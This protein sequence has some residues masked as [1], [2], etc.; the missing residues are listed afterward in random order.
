V[1]DLETGAPICEPITDLRDPVRAVDMVT[2]AGREVLVYARSNNVRARYFWSFEDERQ[3]K[4]ARAE[5]QELRQGDQVP[6]SAESMTDTPPQPPRIGDKLSRHGGRV[7]AVG[8]ANG[9]PIVI[10][11][12]DHG[13]IDLFTVET[14]LPI[15]G[16]LTGHSS[17]IT[18]LAF[19]ELHGG[20]VIASGST[21]GTVRLWDPTDG[22]AIV[23]IVVRSWVRSIALLPPD[24]AIIGTE[25][26]LIARRLA[27]A[28]TDPA[29]NPPDQPP[30]RIRLP[31]DVRATR[32]CP[33]HAKHVQMRE[34]D[35]R[36]VL[37]VCIK[38]IQ[39]G[40]PRFHLL[41][42]PQGRCYVLN[43]GRIVIGTENAPEDLLVLPVRDMY[44][45]AEDTPHA[46]DY[47]G[48][49]FGIAMD[50]HGGYRTLCC[51]TRTDRDSLFDA[52]ARCQCGTN[53][54]FIVHLSIELKGK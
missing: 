47:D 23:V 32:A 36:P 27:F 44:L 24:R 54:Y 3:H 2:M 9:A 17:F 51:Y 38:G 50:G 6:L 46:Y 20:P 30:R 5:S 37:R 45:K 8:S 14:A 39:L 19:E 22:S 35:G 4:R 33:Y 11:G 13:S 12:D 7:V 18:A 10:S 48:C 25:A 52:I 43:D 42:Y 28:S 40:N 41:Q 1:S 21:D 53:E 31:L 29:D 49:H 16:P 15:G 26:G 34:Y